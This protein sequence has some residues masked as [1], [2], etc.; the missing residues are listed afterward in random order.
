MHIDPEQQQGFVGHCLRN[1][2][3]Q[4]DQP[5]DWAEFKRRGRARAAV[6][7]RR[8]ATHRSGLAV[9]AALVLIVLALAVWTRSTRSDVTSQVSR[10]ADLETNPPILE[11]RADPRQPAAVDRRTDAAERWLA[12]LPREPGVVRVGT[13]A[14]VTGLEDRIAQL[15]DYLSAARVEGVQPAA[16]VDAEAQRALLVKSLA[17]VRYAET[18]VAAAR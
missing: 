9:A 7:A 8:R 18:L 5:Y 16:L 4:L 6:A 11:T 1:L 15:D 13:R 14:A 10:R 2:S 3:R 17:Q 12:S